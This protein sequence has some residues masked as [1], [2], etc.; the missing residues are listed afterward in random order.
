MSTVKAYYVPGT[1]QVTHN[2]YHLFFMK[3]WQTM[4]NSPLARQRL[5]LREVK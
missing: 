4:H 3:T 1:H 5:K 2:L